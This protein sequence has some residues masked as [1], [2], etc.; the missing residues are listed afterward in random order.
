MANAFTTLIPLSESPSI[1]FIEEEALH[2]LEYILH[3]FGS[4]TRNMITIIG[5]GTNTMSVSFQFS[6]KRKNVRPIKFSAFMTKF[7]TPSM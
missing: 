5:T 6:E 2:C 7:G 3:S 4:I 1:E